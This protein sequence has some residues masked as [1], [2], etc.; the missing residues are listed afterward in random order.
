MKERPILFSGPMVKAIL[1][2]RKTM[3]RR[4]VKPQPAGA[5]INSAL[6]GKWLSKRFNGLALPKIVDLPMECPYGQPGERLWVR[7]TWQQVGSCDPGY[8]VF[9]ATY[10]RC[11]PSGLENVPQDIR[12]AGYRWRPSI[13]MP[14]WACRLALEVVSVR[15]ERLQEISEEDAR[16]E[17]A[18]IYDWEYGNGEAPE[19]DREAFRCLWDSINAKRGFGWGVNPWVWGVEFK[20]VEASS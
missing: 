15:V 13:H 3:T 10:P 11:L 5:D 14:R 9:R 2:G 12:D 4:V 1:D 7:E 17:G 16:A 18:N 19:N 8:L 6:G 20:R